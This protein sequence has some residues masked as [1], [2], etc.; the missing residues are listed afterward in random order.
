MIELL[1]QAAL[2]QNGHAALAHWNYLFEHLNTQQYTGA[3]YFNA[4]RQLTGDE[5]LVGELEQF[6]HQGFSSLNEVIELFQSYG[7]ELVELQPTDD[8]NA[9]YEIQGWVTDRQ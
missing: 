8:G 3:E 6:T 1:A 4:L 9:Q 7:I 2:K 5:R